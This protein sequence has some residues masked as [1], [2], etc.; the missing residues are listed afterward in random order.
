MST[1]KIADIRADELLH[2][3]ESDFRFD[4]PRHVTPVES[5]DWYISAD[6]LLAWLDAGFKRD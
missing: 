1:N 4:S 5:A 2:W 6:Q 3:L